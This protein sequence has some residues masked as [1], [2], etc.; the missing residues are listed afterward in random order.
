MPLSE[1]EMMRLL[2]REQL[3][4]LAYIR[5]IVRDQHLAEDLFQEV[6]V[7]AVQSRSK[8]ESREHFIRWLRLTAR[9]RSINALQKVGGRTLKLDPR[10][11]DLL[12]EDRLHCDHQNADDELAALRQCV[13]T[14]SPSAQR[15]ISLRYT[16]E[17]DGKQIAVMVKRS[18]ASVYMSL[19][20]IRRALL[21]CVER[22]LGL[23]RGEA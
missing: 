7:L 13:A 23:D 22:Q 2:L 3:P 10:V 4:L 5:A 1:E 16:E 14:L 9:H 17:L 21:N 6:S 20:R 11:L 18:A 15:L 8:I 12:D 19:S